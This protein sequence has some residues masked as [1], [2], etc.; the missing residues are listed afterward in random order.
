MATKKPDPDELATWPKRRQL[1]TSENNPMK[2][3]M[4][5]NRNGAPRKTKAAKELAELIQRE[6]VALNILAEFI[7][8]GRAWRTDHKVAP[9]SVA[10]LRELW[11][12]GYGQ[13]PQKIEGEGI[14]ALA[15]LARA[16][17]K[18]DDDKGDG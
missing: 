2:P 5:N 13:A 12:R 8:I 15:A 11:N 1:F 3:G 6:D 9:A 14:D 10:A 18:S 17:V 16:L 4:T 7:D